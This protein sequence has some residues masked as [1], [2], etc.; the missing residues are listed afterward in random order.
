MADIEAE[1]AP[2]Q[3]PP[4]RMATEAAAL[5]WFLSLAAD[6]AIFGFLATL[7]LSNAANAAALAVRWACGEDSRAAAFV[8]EF[9]KASSF[10]TALLFVAAL[11][12]PLRRRASRNAVTREIGGDEGRPATRS[13]ENTRGRRRRDGLCGPVT[14]PIL[15]FFLVL[16]AV[17]VLMEELAPA[18]GS[19]A[20]RVGS[21]LTDIGCSFCFF[22]F[23]E[24]LDQSEASIHQGELLL[25]RWVH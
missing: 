10:T 19:C 22:I 3:G 17:G 12:L 16:V 20:S 15:A 21:M 2:P 25:N 18:K 11:L 4:K 9:A 13:P 7:W 6:V 1:T 24:L 23:S 14:T 8:R 5:R